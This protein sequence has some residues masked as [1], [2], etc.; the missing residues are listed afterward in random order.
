[1]VV[2]KFK[3]VQILLILTAT[4]SGCLSVPQLIPDFFKNSGGK[5]RNVIMASTQTTRI[6]AEHSKSVTVEYVNMKDKVFFSIHKF[7]NENDNDVHASFYDRRTGKSYFVSNLNDA[8]NRVCVLDQ[9]NRHKHSFPW[10]YESH[11]GRFHIFGAAAIWLNAIDLEVT[12]DF[13]PDDYNKTALTWSMYKSKVQVDFVFR[14]ENISG[15][16]QFEIDSIKLNRQPTFNPTN[17]S[18]NLVDELDE[19][20]QVT[21]IE[22]R[23]VSKEKRRIYDEINLLCHTANERSVLF[24][25]LLHFQRESADDLF[26]I[27]FIEQSTSDDSSSSDS[28]S[29]RRRL[30][31]ETYFHH[32]K[33][34]ATQIRNLTMRK[35]GQK[36]DLTDDDLKTKV[37]LKRMIENADISSSKTYTISEACVEYKLDMDNDG[38]TRCFENARLLMPRDHL[39]RWFAHFRYANGAQ[40]LAAVPGISAL[41]LNS[42]ELDHKSFQLERKLIEFEGMDGQVSSQYNCSEW[43]ILD[44]KTKRMIHFYFELD[45]KQNVFAQQSIS[46]LKRID[47]INDDEAFKDKGKVNKRFDVLSVEN[48]I[49]HKDILLLTEKPTGCTILPKRDDKNEDERKNNEEDEY[50]PEYDDFDSKNNDTTTDDFDFWNQFDAQN[51]DALANEILVNKPIPSFELFLEGSSSY[52]MFSLISF[53]KNDKKF[54]FNEVMDSN[55]QASYTFGDSISG[56]DLFTYYV[57]YTHNF[58]LLLKKGEQ[59][60]Q[61]SENALS[62]SWLRILSNSIEIEFEQKSGDITTYIKKNATVY[63]LGAFRTRAEN[64]GSVM[65][66]TSTSDPER[67]NV[68][69]IF[70]EYNYDDDWSQIKFKFELDIDYMKSLESSEQRPSN[71]LKFTGLSFKPLKL[72]KFDQTNFQIT[73][74]QRGSQD[75][76][77]EIDHSC[78]K[79]FDELLEKPIDDEIVDPSF[80]QFRNKW[81]NYY[82]KYHIDDN[83]VNINERGKQSIGVG[84]QVVVEEMFDFESHRGKVSIQQLPSKRVWDIYVDNEIIYLFGVNKC[85]FIHEIGG[86]GSTIDGLLSPS[87]PKND[88]KVY[89]GLGAL[90]KSLTDHSKAN[91]ISHKVVGN[92]RT[93]MQLDFDIKTDDSVTVNK[94]EYYVK[95]NF[96]VKK[97]GP[98]VLIESVSIRQTSDNIIEKAELENKK[99]T[100]IVLKTNQIS[101]QHSLDLPEECKKLVSEELFPSKESN[102]NLNLAHISSEVH[103]EKPNIGIKSKQL[104]TV[105]EYFYGNKRRIK[106]TGIGKTKQFNDSCD[107]IDIIIDSS[108]YQI[109][110][111]SKKFSCKKT[112]PSLNFNLMPYSYKYSDGF[113]ISHFYNIKEVN[114]KI[115]N[116]LQV[117]LAPISLWLN[118]AKSKYKLKNCNKFEFVPRHESDDEAEHDMQEY[119]W[120]LSGKTPI[121]STTSQ[122]DSIVDWQ[123]LLVYRKRDDKNEPPLFD[124]KSIDVTESHNGLTSSATIFIYMS[125]NYHKQIS[126]LLENELIDSITLP[127]AYGC[128]NY[129][130]SPVTFATFKDTHENPVLGYDIPSAYSIDMMDLRYEASLDVINANS[131]IASRYKSPLTRYVSGSF[132]RNKSLKLIKLS[133]EAQ[134]E[135]AEMNSAEDA[136]SRFKVIE[137]K[138]SKTQYLIDA[139]SGRCLIRKSNSLKSEDNFQLN[140][141]LNSL[142]KDT[143]NGEVIVL[144]EQQIN[145]LLFDMRYAK[146]LS[147][148][149]KVDTTIDSNTIILSYERNLDYFELNKQL[150]GPATLIT[151][152]KVE[153]EDLLNSKGTDKREHKSFG[154]KVL[155][156]DTK[157]TDIKAVF[158][159]SVNSIEN[160]NTANFVSV[161]SLKECYRTSGKL[162][163]DKFN[164]QRRRA[165]RKYVVTY[166][167]SDSTDVAIKN[168]EE[169]SNAINKITTNLFNIHNIHPLQFISTP[170]LYIS[171]LNN[172]RLELQFELFEPRT[173]FEFM[174]QFDSFK[175]PSKLEEHAKTK[176]TNSLAECS[177][178]CDNHKCSAMSY[179]L[180]SKVCKIVKSRKELSEIKNFIEDNFKPS[181]GSDKNDNC[182][183]YYVQDHNL[184]IDDEQ[185]SVFEQ[186]LATITSLL[187]TFQVDLNREAQIPI[188]FER[189][190]KFDLDV[191]D[192]DDDD[193]TDQDDNTDNEFDSTNSIFR[194]ISSHKQFNFA[195]IDP[196]HVSN[197]HA[198]ES[199][200]LTSCQNT[201]TCYLYSYCTKSNLC[202]MISNQLPS[203][204][205]IRRE[206]DNRILPTVAQDD[207]YIYQTDFSSSY[208]R[209][210]S[211]STYKTTNNYHKLTD[212]TIDQCA[213]HCT[214]GR[215]I[216][217]YQDECLSF[218]YCYEFNELYVTTTST[219][220][221]QNSHLLT[222]KFDE[223]K[224][225]NNK[226]VD[227][228]K[229]IICDHYAKDILSTYKK[230]KNVEL[231]SKEQS[232]ILVKDQHQCAAECF[233]LDDCHA[234]EYCFN[235]NKDP[236]F[237]C[238][239]LMKEYHNLILAN[240]TIDTRL[241][242][243]S[244]VC[245]IYATAPQTSD[246]TTNTSSSSKI[247]IIIIIAFVAGIAFQILYIKLMKLLRYRK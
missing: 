96:E 19:L 23:K 211:V 7:G 129:I 139:I 4:I 98:I 67:K 22:A 148:T 157:K 54:F 89:I 86:I 39:M 231:I 204:M 160:I 76:K 229:K 153:K 195:E 198:S 140:I 118:A 214:I 169:V 124:L 203:S 114:S 104:F 29:V 58:V 37:Y 63:G 33:V 207:C 94:K 239:L 12:R 176:L 171:K 16:Y 172:G 149:E 241:T 144:Q 216:S 109:F 166:A 41:L 220:Y 3:F 101:D 240:N 138:L 95:A 163:N 21:S 64:S 209:F 177:K 135:K 175:L 184:K 108:N 80:D 78:Q 167:S 38:S 47:I 1:M 43:R 15:K 186:K 17:G 189:V 77:I 28:K 121:T 185:L 227:K 119:K 165:T 127:Q 232:T 6:G 25:N 13:S 36:D 116:P 238:Y 247:L 242:T 8:E 85:K 128:S 68:K 79:L 225:K 200:C 50:M 117:Y 162:T 221:L 133:V 97:N 174:N 180:S 191:E 151:S 49:D 155:L 193:D 48:T 92:D 236:S 131:G 90:W 27:K 103:L 145:K 51:F 87:S 196:E 61:V 55:L 110:D 146:L 91:E 59:C 168:N 46:N 190:Y 152:I 42:A 136:S 161:S 210:E 83:L 233:K 32:E 192:D 143:G 235:A 245:S 215:E 10:K 120:K 31:T 226:E 115:T 122:S 182:Y 93:S 35:D 26:R 107:D 20:I 224:F 218:D 164:I 106:T 142:I 60:V 88:T 223:S 230:Y 40:I 178:Y 134:L 53:S 154:V 141:K 217:K 113:D 199:N 34:F 244:L 213:A 52:S 84:A 66:L 206:D 56:N 246:T 181:E 73:N 11:K 111:I 75:D 24:P 5:Y 159:L 57:S 105:D 156:F 99:L 237:S 130:N 2:F 222:D 147:A 126:P 219:C 234:F 183:Y 30:V 243:K 45:K 228:N 100:L 9:F 102:L 205:Y 173:S 208:M 125:T 137:D 74:Y 81:N 170:K 197:S 158:S 72:D 188:D 201:E 150:M 132:S 123:Y 202:S 187:D 212:F 14:V 65:Y 82:F 112:A 179:C 70:W 194:L 18:G 44:K 71:I 62:D 69:N